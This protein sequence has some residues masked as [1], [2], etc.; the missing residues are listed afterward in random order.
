MQRAVHNRATIHALSAAPG[1]GHTSGRSRRCCVRS[2]LKRKNHWKKTMKIHLLFAL[3]A[4]AISF[5]IPAFAQQK[6][7]V[8]PKTAQQIHALAAKF[9][10]AFNKHDPAAVAALYTEDAV[11][12]TYHGNYHGRKRIE[13]GYA[14][15]SFKRWN[16]HN[17][18]TTISEVIRVGNEVRATGT[19]SC[20]LTTGEGAAGADN[21]HCR[22]VIVREGDTWKIREE[23]LGSENW[24]E[25][26]LI[27]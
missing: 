9:N 24:K 25:E 19:W 22:W 3:V 11:W 18:V 12:K 5:A 15:W 2:L 17:W 20:D 1:G 21:G 13:Q 4:L 8:D 10:E 14:D 27:H 6:E 7:A 23:T 26:G 16:K